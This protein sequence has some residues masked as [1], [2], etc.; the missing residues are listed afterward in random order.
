MTYIKKGYITERYVYEIEKRL[1][2]DLPLEPF[3]QT[4]LPLETVGNDHIDDIIKPGEK[5]TH[6]P[7]DFNHIIVTTLGRVINL[8]TLKMYS[9]RIG[10]SSFHMYLSAKGVKEKYKLDMKEIFLQEGW[11][12]DFEK[13]TQNY[14]DNNW[15]CVYY[16]K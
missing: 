13:L 8:N 6:L 4:V 14:V 5:Y 15:R 2:N 10:N 9:P 12:Y 3:L 1:Y 11:D 16:K 7:F